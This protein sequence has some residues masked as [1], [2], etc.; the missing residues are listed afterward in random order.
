MAH[1]LHTFVTVIFLTV[2]SAKGSIDVRVTWSP[3]P[4]STLSPTFT[5][6][7]SSHFFYRTDPD[8]ASPHPPTPPPSYMT[9]SAFKASGQHDNCWQLPLPNHTP[10]VSHSIRHWTCHQWRDDRIHGLTTITSLTLSC[11]V[12]L[13]LVITLQNGQ[14]WVSEYVNSSNSHWGSWHWCSLTPLLLVSPSASHE[15][16]HLL[17]WKMSV[18]IEYKET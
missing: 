14:K 12:S 18:K 3:W 9:H 6:Q 16:S 15:W 7:Y 10:K 8:T 17:M 5:G 4:G 13:S 2:Y 11:N 1:D